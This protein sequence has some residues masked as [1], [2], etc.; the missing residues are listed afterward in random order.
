MAGPPL[1]SLDLK[2]RCLGDARL[3]LEVLASSRDEAAITMEALGG[4]ADRADLRRMAFE[5]HGLKGT[6]AT[7]GASPFSAARGALEVSARAGDL[8]GCRSAL[9]RARSA[10]SASLPALAA[11]AEGEVGP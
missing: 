2:E 3:A 10:W 5:A 7:V 4:L 6:A 8:G 11:A 9:G 1:Q